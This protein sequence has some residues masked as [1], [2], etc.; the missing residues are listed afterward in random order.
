MNVDLTMSVT[1]DRTAIAA[2]SSPSGVTGKAIQRAADRAAARL[3]SNIVD[4]GLIDTG[5]MLGGVRTEVVSSGEEGVVI[6]VG[7]P[8]PYAIYHRRPFTDTLAAV[9]PSDTNP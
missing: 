7:T 6:E 4:E 2:L 9:R 8:V 1:L 3:A 5:A